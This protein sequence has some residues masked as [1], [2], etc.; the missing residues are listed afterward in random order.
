MANI[1]IISGPSGAGEDSIIEGLKKILPIERVITTTTRKMRP[2]ES[3]K[4]PYY[5]ISKKEFAKKIKKNK[6]LEY[7]KE[8][9]DN[10]YGTTHTEIKRVKKG[11]KIGIWKIE[12]KGVKNVKKIMPE[13]KSI[14]INAPLDV[15]KNRIKRR[16]KATKEFIKKRMDYTKKWLKH[17]NIYSYEVINQEGNLKKA[18]NEVAEII[19]S[20]L[21]PTSPRCHSASR[22]G[23]KRLSN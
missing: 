6:F 2:R 21:D 20:N 18:V 15:M 12:Y 4:N 13:I 17:K 9:N 7:A 16:D 22:G 10:Y 8:Y 23:T 14:L 3:Q 1:F 19:K 5:F 11:K